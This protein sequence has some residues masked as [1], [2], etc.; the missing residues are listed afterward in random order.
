M[1][2]RGY[3]EI[4]TLGSSSWMPYTPQGVEET[5]DD[6]ITVVVTLM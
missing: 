4:A 6:D 2:S 1:R 5:D 3:L